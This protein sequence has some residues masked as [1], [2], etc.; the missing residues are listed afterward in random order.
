MTLLDHQLQ[1]K[2]VVL[3]DD[4]GAERPA[5]MRRR[6]NRD[7]SDAP[8]VSLQQPLPLN[9]LLLPYQYANTS[10][11]SYSTQWK[12]Y[13]YHQQQQDFDVRPTKKRRV[14]SVL[15]TSKI[16][17]IVYGLCMFHD[18]N[19]HHNSNHPSRGHSYIVACTSR[20]DILVWDMNLLEDTCRDDTKCHVTSAPTT[21]RSTTP[22]SMIID[23]DDDD[24]DKQEYEVD[25]VEQM[26]SMQESLRE[27]KPHLPSHRAI[28]S[29]S[30]FS[31]NNRT[32][33]RDGTH[34][35]ILRLR[36][37]YSRYNDANNNSNDEMNRDDNTAAKET[38][39]RD[40]SNVLYHCHMSTMQP[41]RSFLVV[42]GDHGTSS[43]SY[44]C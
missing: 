5:E 6:P 28:S 17:L 12:R 13:Q 29:S 31:S 43:T 27:P 20:G 36:L 18:E 41:N 37:Q 4:D 1:C 32:T 15:P 21:K 11:L 30:S 42:S 3:E 35:P 40:N 34:R 8:P 16:P 14:P 26:T 19:N 2:V 23:D 24:D 9:G 33:R 38:G 10:L 7:G 44:I 22:W 39:R 25:T